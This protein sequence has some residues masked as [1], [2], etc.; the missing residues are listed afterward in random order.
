[1][2]VSSDGRHV[3]SASMCEKQQKY[4]IIDDTHGLSFQFFIAFAGLDF[5]SNQKS[6]KEEFLYLF[7]VRSKP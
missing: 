7:L 2:E 1:M 3:A 4:F 5:L 6:E